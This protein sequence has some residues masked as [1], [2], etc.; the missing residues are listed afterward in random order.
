VRPPAANID[1]VRWPRPRASRTCTRTCR[2][3]CDRR[4][5]RKHTCLPPPAS[6]RNPFAAGPINPQQSTVASTSKPL[7]VSGGGLVCSQSYSLRARQSPVPHPVVVG[8]TRSGSRVWSTGRGVDYSPLHFSFGIPWLAN[9]VM[10][11]CGRCSEERK[12]DGSDGG[13]RP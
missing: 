2:N 3:R 12:G 7:I 10:C 4:D 11:V 5:C 6:L 8:K 9:I 1:A 13:H